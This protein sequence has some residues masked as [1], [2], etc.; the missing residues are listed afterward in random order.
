MGRATR[1]SSHAVT[2]AMVAERAGVSAMTV[3]NV[4]NGQKK[5][6]DAKRAAV[7]AAVE[8]LNY[9]PN[10]AARALASAAPAQIGLLYHDPQ[11]AYLSALLLGA[12]DTTRRLG[13]QLLIQHTPQVEIGAALDALRTLKRG[14]AN[15]FLLPPPFCEL[16]GGSAELAALGLP[17]LALSPGADIPGLPGVRID[18]FAAARDLTGR[19]LRLGH[20]RI[21]FI[22][23]PSTHSASGP[24]ME[25]YR[26][27]LQEGGVPFDPVLVAPG[28]FTFESGL[29]AAGALLTMTPRPTAIFAA[30]D[31]MAAA[32]VSTAHRMGLHIPADLSVVGFDDTPIATRIWPMLTTVR[33]P[34]ARISEVAVEAL[35]DVLKSPA[36]PPPLTSRLLPYEIVERDSTGPPT[37][38][39]VAS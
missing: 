22:S 35:V 25:G 3:S 38:R 37:A 2:I 9:V 15:G 4:L 31:D 21:A 36:E 30:N 6:H 1:R 32:V 29:A 28:A 27:A 12:L 16:L 7:L 23:G 11:V 14:G 13:A 10:P 24:R 34:V 20:R 39:P 19:L 8:A 5:V 17:V 18:T 26:A 33:Q